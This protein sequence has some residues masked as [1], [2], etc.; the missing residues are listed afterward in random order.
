M[1]SGKVN[2]HRLSGHLGP[3]LLI[4]YFLYCSRAT[5]TVT[6]VIYSLCLRLV[7]LHFACGQLHLILL[8][9]S[10]H[11]YVSVTSNSV[12]IYST[13]HYMQYMYFG[14]SQ[15]QNVALWYMFDSQTMYCY[16]FFLVLKEL[17][18]FQLKRKGVTRFYVGIDQFRCIK[19]Q[20]QTVDLNTRLLGINT[21]FVI[22]DFSL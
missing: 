15:L 18:H 16:Q 11:L 6:Q 13:V 4:F 2:P 22:C 21:E 17:L 12:L 8:A 7:S 9:V 14:G 10:F 3:T 19:I 1:F 5:S 20:S